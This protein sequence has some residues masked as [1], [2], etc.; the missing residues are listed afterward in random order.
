MKKNE[1]V[2]KVYFDKIPFSVIKA[3]YQSNIF[4]AD[5]T[6]VRQLVG[7]LPETDRNILIMYAELKSLK[8]LSKAF[9]CSRST[10]WNRIS[11][12]RKKVAKNVRYD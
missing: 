9:N 12:I 3:E 4:E 8:K 5:D 1:S 2:S 7:C 10:M 11:E 6:N